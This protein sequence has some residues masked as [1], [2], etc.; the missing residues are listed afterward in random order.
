MWS[1]SKR[2]LQYVNSKRQWRTWTMCVMSSCISKLM[3]YFAFKLSLALAMSTTFGGMKC[4]WKPITN[5]ISSI[6]Q[7][8]WVMKTTHDEEHQLM[9]WLFYLFALSHFDKF[10]KSYG[11]KSLPFNMHYFGHRMMKTLILINTTHNT[12]QNGC[13]CFFL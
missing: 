2:K 5:H 6:Q 1:N 8:G 11:S 10:L 13:F 9:I 4:Q 12:N 3:K 7:R